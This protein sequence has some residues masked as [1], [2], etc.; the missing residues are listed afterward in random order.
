M[1]NTDLKILACLKENARINTSVIGERI[2][3]SVSAV[4]E[5][6]RKLENLGIIK[7]YTV[8]LDHKL[9]GKDLLSYISVSLE[10]PKYNENFINS[11][12]K[13]SQVIEC[14][15]TTGDFDFLL[16]VITDSAAAL[17]DVLNEIKSISGVSLTRTLIVLST[18]KSDV[19][20][21]PEFMET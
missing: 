4:S 5:R 15:Y 17:S 2:N 11:I 1:D 20:V 18:S 10:H 14:H 16:K 13:N 8:I 19:S 21:L 12:D 9:I 7:Q 6:I 3:M